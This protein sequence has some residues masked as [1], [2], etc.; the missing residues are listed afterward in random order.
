MLRLSRF[1]TES[2]WTPKSKSNML[3]P[4]TN[5]PTSSQRAISCSHFSPMNN[6]QTMSMRLIQQERPGEDERVVSKSQPMWK[7][8]VEGCRSVSNSAKLECISQPGDT[9]SKKFKIGFHQ[10]RDSK[11]STAWSS[12]VWPA[13]LQYRETCGGNDKESH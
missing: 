13:E 8:V 5:F 11:E 4:G 2:T 3:T 1:L 6:L 9:Q 12:Q 7:F 10:Y